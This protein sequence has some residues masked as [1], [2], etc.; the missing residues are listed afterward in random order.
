MATRQTGTSQTSELE[1]DAENQVTTKLD[2]PG[3]PPRL[4]EQ[5]SPG[6]EYELVEV[7]RVARRQERSESVPV[8]GFV[9]ANDDPFIDRFG[10]ISD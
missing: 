9:I 10:L 7:E 3:F 4:D 6:A 5:F 8:G 1:Q 2:I